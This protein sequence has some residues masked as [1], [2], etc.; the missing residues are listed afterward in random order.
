M[1]FLFIYSSQPRKLEN[2]FPLQNMHPQLTFCQVSQGL[3]ASQNVVKTLGRLTDYSRDVT[4]Y[5][6]EVFITCW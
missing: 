6:V 2:D 4:T 5:M 1:V 3:L